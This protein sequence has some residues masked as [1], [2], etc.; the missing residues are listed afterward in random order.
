[1]DILKN[2]ISIFPLVLLGSFFILYNIL[3]ER[4]YWWLEQE[5]GINETIQFICF[6]TASYI[7][8]RNAKKMFVL[9]TKWFSII[10]LFALG[11]L[12]IAIEEISWGQ[13]IFG[14]ETSEWLKNNNYQQ[15]ISI[16]N[17]TPTGFLSWFNLHDLFILVGLYGGLMH[18][19]FPHGANH[20][21]QLR[22]IIV[23]KKK[24]SLY[25]LP[26]G[27]FYIYFEYFNRLGIYVIGSHQE[28]VE[29]I[30]SIGFLLIAFDH[31]NFISKPENLI[32]NS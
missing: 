28:V 3:S 12:F 4:V 21:A 8:F 29:L 6:I 10:F 2:Y 25:F 9:N 32:P 31:R 23:P 26:T 18:L 5:D 22:D 13:R 27:I 14:I 17:I 11:L 24:Y 7:S 15:E 16:H 30:L 20:N 19:I 1:M